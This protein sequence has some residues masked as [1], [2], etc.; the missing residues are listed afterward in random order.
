MPS[1][2]IP[3]TSQPNQT[4]TVSLNIDGSTLTLR[5]NIRFNEMAGWWVM[6]IADQFGNM[7]I[8]G[9]PLVTGDYPAA[10]MLEQYA[11][12]EIG[13]CFMINISQTPIDSPNLTNLGN[14]FVLLWAD[15]PTS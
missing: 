8:D 9:V 12:L 3:L 6:I 14:D 13:S 5:L 2:I 10:N 4:M 1:Q 15:T 11:Y 7:I